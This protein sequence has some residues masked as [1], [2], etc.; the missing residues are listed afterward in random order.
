[1]KLVVRAFCRLCVAALVLG[2]V[3]L[4]MAAGAVGIAS[5]A[6]AQTIEVRG[7]Q[8]VEAATIRQYFQLGPGERLDAVKIDSAYK[9]LIATGLF[10]DVQIVPERGHIVV[11]VIE[12][13]VINRVQFEG[14]KRIKDEQLTAEVQSKPRGTLSRAQVQADVV[15][16][17]EVYRANGRFDVRVD[18]KFITL[19]NNRVDLVFEITEGPKTTVKQI[20]FVG[21][22]T[23]GDRTLKDVIKT[24]E[25]G[26]LSFLKTNDIYDADRVE[27]DRDLLRRFYLKKG[28]ADIRVL[29]AGAQFDPAKNGFI[30][31][32]TIDEGELYRFGP[33]E[34]LSNVRDVDIGALR[35]KLRMS[36][37]SNYN[38]EAVEKSIE[39]ITIELSKRGY[40]F[41]Q[42]RPR[43]DRDLQNHVIA[44]TFVVEEGARAYIERI[45][46]RGNSRTRDYV[47]RR[48]FDIAEG[49]AYN[50]VLIDRAERRLKNLAY[51][52]SVKITNEPGSAPDRVVVNVDVEEQSTGEFSVSGGYSTSDGIIGEV[53]VA[54]RNLLGRGLYAKVS[55]SWGS[56]SKGADFSFV[57]PYFLGYRLSA[58]FDLFYKETSQSTYQSYDSKTFGGGLR[59]GV[60][61]REDLALQLRYSAYRQEITLPALLNNCNNLNPDFVNTFPTPDQFAIN[62][63]FQAQAAASQLAGNTAQTDCYLDSEAS[64]AIKSA[65]LAGPTITSLV[66]YTLSFSNLDNNKAPTS[67]LYA[68][69]RQ[70]FAGVG[71][72]VNFIKTT[73]DLR[74]YYPIYADIV[75]LIRLQAGHVQGWGGEQLRMLD[76]F[77]MGP[78]LVRGFAP[79]G[80]G[81]RDLTVGTTNDALGGTNYWGATMEL[82]SPIPGIPKDMGLK[83]AAFADAGS[84]WDY[85]GLTAQQLFNQFNGQTITLSDNSMQIRSSVGVG[86]LWDSPFGP[87]RIDYAYAIQHEPWCVNGIT[88]LTTSCDIK[89]SI[90]FSGGTRF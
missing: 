7:N 55:A 48:E 51:F 73:G 90:R 13:S 28:Y 9:A 50:R 56:Y 81:P 84:L 63:A 4:G 79:N 47:I 72:D 14:N 23:Y 21:N 44:L 61:L 70:D 87:L 86:L 80:I 17:L 36:A 58:G 41:A 3:T 25:S 24:G 64:L 49:D 15:R 74:Y 54:E 31:T 53:S 59:F 57:E 77:F 22:N 16:I 68:E 67:G 85:R 27:A 26:I 52:K 82:Q 42:V 45:N 46:I 20:I 65:V 69:I 83:V 78:N 10:Q 75:S 33:I 5:P 38:A 8:R 60:P 18:P 62:A 39:D 43:G 19:P 12:A 30:L 34:I 29:S 89:Q 6:T 35:S 40:A 37:G 66:G 88:A 2:T 71:G 1:M 76:H 11:T 32:F